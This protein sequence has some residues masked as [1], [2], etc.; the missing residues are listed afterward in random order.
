MNS[1]A[2]RKWLVSATALACGFT[3]I[4]VVSANVFPDRTFAVLTAVD[5]R[6]SDIVSRMTPIATGR[7]RSVEETEINEAVFRDLID[8]HS[9]K[10]P[11]LFFLRVNEKDAGDDVVS[12]LSAMGRRVE[13]WS[14]AR[15]GEQHLSGPLDR[16]TREHGILLSLGPVKWLFG[17]R[18]EVSAAM[19]CGILCGQ[20]GVYC[21]SK[22]RGYWTVDAYKN[23]FFN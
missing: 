10:L 11:R 18:V 7:D 5:K 13:K 23:Q 16:A 2:G 19:Y 9:H 15:F 6:Y 20:G 21:L 1:K 22:R 12:R 3:S 14:Q 4:A 8:W 17:D